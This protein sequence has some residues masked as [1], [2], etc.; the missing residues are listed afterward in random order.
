LGKHLSNSKFNPLA[1]KLTLQ[2]GVEGLSFANGKEEGISKIFRLGRGI[3]WQFA[4]VSGRAL[5]LLTFN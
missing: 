2:K 4:C 5:K 3:S 1:N